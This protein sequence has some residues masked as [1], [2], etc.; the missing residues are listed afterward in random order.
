M[1]SGEYTAKSIRFNKSFVVVFYV[2]LKIIFLFT[3]KEICHEGCNHLSWFVTLENSR[4]NK[5]CT[6][7]NGSMFLIFM[8]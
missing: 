5:S 6:Q 1:A 7:L 2:L 4:N 3:H 8:H